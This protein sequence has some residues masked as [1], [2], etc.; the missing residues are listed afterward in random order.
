MS[1][2]IG[3]VRLRTSDARGRRD[4]TTGRWRSG[5]PPREADVTELDDASEQAARPRFYP[6]PL[7]SNEPSDG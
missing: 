2:P 6:F 7:R 1:A 3:R 5:D 4:S